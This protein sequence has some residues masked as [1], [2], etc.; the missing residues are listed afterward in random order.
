MAALGLPEYSAGRVHF[1]IQSCNVVTT[2]VILFVLRAQSERQVNVLRE[3][4]FV[5]EVRL[6]TPGRKQ[7][8]N[9]SVSLIVFR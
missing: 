8:F 9:R 6:A 4:V 5:I 7:D 2:C 1:P 3:K